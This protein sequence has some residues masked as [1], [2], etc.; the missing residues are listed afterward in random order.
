M[1]LWCHVAAIGDWTLVLE[2]SCPGQF[3]RE[4]VRLFSL[5]TIGGRADHQSTV[6]GD[7]SSMRRGENTGRGPL[8]RLDAT[9][10]A[11][12]LASGIESASM[13]IS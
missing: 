5:A 3:L 9:G 8:G 7:D 13:K 4:N 12:C 10:R 6:S 11:R 1:P 2:E